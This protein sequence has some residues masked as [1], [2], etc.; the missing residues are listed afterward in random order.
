MKELLSRHVV[1]VATYTREIQNLSNTSGGWGPSATMAFKR[2]TGLLPVKLDQPYSKI[3]TFLRCKAACILSAGLCNH[4][5]EKRQEV[6]PQ[7]MQL[8]TPACMI[9]CLTSL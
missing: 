6:I 7:A 5:P 4:V 3:L 9:S 8:M 2:L 1:F